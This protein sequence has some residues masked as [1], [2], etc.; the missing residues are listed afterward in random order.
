[1]ETF[2]FQFHSQFKYIKDLIK[3]NK[4]GSIRSVD[5]K[6]GFPPFQNLKDIRYQKSLNGGSLDAVF[7]SQNCNFI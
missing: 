5:V 6:F 3:N 1:M 4:L 2:Q 7:I